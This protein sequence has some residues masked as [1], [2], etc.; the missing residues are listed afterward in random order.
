MISY[1][2]SL[3]SLHYNFQNI[4]DIG[5]Y[6]NPIN[7]FLDKNFCPESVVIVEP[8]LNALSAVVPCTGTPGGTHILFLQIT[9]KFYIKIK[10]LVPKSYSIVCIGCDSH[11]GPNRNLLETSF[12]RPYKLFLEYP[13]EYVHNAAFKKMMGYGEF[14]FFSDPSIIC[15]IFH[16]YFCESCNRF[17]LLS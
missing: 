1:S 14:H 6:Y 3:F 9:F 12:E 4:L 15:L 10:N 5:A 7:L 8:I 11:Y 16:L 2:L 17:Y 13:S